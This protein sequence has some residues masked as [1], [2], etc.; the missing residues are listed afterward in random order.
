MLSHEPKKWM[1]GA[2]T[3]I[4]NLPHDWTGIGEDIRKLVT[5]SVGRPHHPNAW[6]AL[7]NAAIRRKHLARCGEMRAMTAVKSHGRLSPILY[8][9][10]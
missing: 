3:L 6:G 1:E 2:L 5:E 7:V 9:P 4:S 10:V 8:R